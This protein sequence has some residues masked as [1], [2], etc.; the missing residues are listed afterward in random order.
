MTI[1]LRNTDSPGSSPVPADTNDGSRYA[2]YFTPD[3]TTECAAIWSAWLDNPG[4][5]LTRCNLWDEAITSQPDLCQIDLAT[6]TAQARVY[7]LHATLK[8]PF[9]LKQGLG[10]A[11]LLS[12]STAIAQRFTSFALPS[13]EPHW[14]D[15]FLALRP[16]GPCAQIDAIAAACV[17]ELD[18]LRAPLRPQERARRL[19]LPLSE[20]QLSL[21]SEWGYPFVLDEFRFHLTLCDGVANLSESDRQW[22]E[23]KIRQIH[24]RCE[25]DWPAFDALSI[26]EQTQANSPFVPRH[27]IALQR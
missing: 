17:R 14:I 13:L 15:S 26:F 16:A 22:L 27:R 21:F 23:R 18:W 20:R 12:A 19:Q 24:R 4:E 2:I 5:V 6:V 1:E 3:A 11:D 9:R 10:Y 8:A 25:H 7:G